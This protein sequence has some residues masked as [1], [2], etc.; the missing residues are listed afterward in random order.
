MLKF[1][2]YIS[3]KIN[4]TENWT[5]KERWKNERIIIQRFTKRKRQNTLE[6]NNSLASFSLKNDCRN[7]R[8]RNGRDKMVRKQQKETEVIRDSRYFT[9]V[10]TAI[11]L[12]FWWMT[13]SRR[14]LHEAESFGGSSPLVQRVSRGQA[15]PHPCPPH[16][17]QAPVHHCES[18][19]IQT[20]H[21]STYT[22]SHTPQEE[23]GDRTKRH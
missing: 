19:N 7:Y 22:H 13:V 18:N 11:G 14:G 4:T 6:C 16:L 15:W 21:I 23:R 17:W 8:D 12:M 2:C 3:Q 5:K 20:P 9:A 1:K 10:C